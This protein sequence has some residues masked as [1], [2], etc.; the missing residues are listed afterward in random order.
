[1]R[2]GYVGLAQQ[3]LSSAE[4]QEIADMVGKILLQRLHMRN[5]Q[6]SYPLSAERIQAIQAGDITPMEFDYTG[7]D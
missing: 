3:Q 5:E 2:A 6:F 4:W 1:M 7:L